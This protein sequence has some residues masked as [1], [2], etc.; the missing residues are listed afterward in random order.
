MLSFS[1]F[2]VRHPGA[3]PG[4]AN[5]NRTNVGENMLRWFAK[6]LDFYPFLL[7]FPD[8]SEGGG[9]L[10]LS[11]LSLFP[12]LFYRGRQAKYEIWVLGSQG[13]PQDGSNPE[14]LGLRCK[15]VNNNGGNKEMGG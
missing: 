7:P 12:I 1:P 10:Q 2:P 9:M 5:I 3:H 15:N 6:F 14:S 8:P 4:R 13:G 11:Y